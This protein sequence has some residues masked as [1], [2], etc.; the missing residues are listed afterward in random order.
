MCILITYFSIQ[1][2]PEKDKG[3][4][5][6]NSYVNGIAERYSNLSPNS[7]KDRI[8]SLISSEVTSVR[9]SI[10]AY[11]AKDYIASYA[12]EL[13]A[14][15]QTGSVADTLSTSIVRQYPEKF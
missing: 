2:Q 14:N 7:P 13:E 4:N 6:L 10:D 5:D 1:R 15:N 11:A 12:K 9:G 8:Q 3:A